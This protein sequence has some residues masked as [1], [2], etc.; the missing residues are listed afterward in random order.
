[1]VMV[2][3]NLYSAIDTKSLMHWYQFV[4]CWQNRWRTW[5]TR[6]HEPV[7]SDW[8]FSEAQCWVCI[9]RR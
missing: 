2:N 7:C 5:R 3:V 4:I 9:G 6:G 8:R 1:M